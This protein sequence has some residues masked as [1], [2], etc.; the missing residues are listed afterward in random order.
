MS[1]KAKFAYTNLT[2]CTTVSKNAKNTDL[3]RSWVGGWGGDPRPLEICIFYVF[4]TVVQLVR[5]VHA[6]AAFFKTVVHLVTLI[7]I[8]L[9]IFLYLFIYVYISISFISIC[10][11]LSIYISLYLCIQFATRYLSLYIYIHMIYI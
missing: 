5:L 8:Y 3:Q 9:Y 11:S 4:E 10:I 7:S 6:N 1:K 2:N